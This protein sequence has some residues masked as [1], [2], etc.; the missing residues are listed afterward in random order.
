MGED[1]LVPLVYPRVCGG[2]RG[3]HSACQTR[4]GLSP[5]VRGNPSPPS[6]PPAW[7]GSIPA[8]AGE[9]CI[10]CHRPNNR[11]VY[12]RVCGGTPE[13]LHNP[14]T[15]GGLSPRVRGN[16]A[17]AEHH[18]QR[19]RSIPACAGE[20][21]LQGQRPAPPQVYPRV[22]GGTSRLPLGEM[23][24]RGLSPRVRGNPVT[25]EVIDAGTGSIP[26][27]A[28]EPARRHGTGRSCWVYPRVCGG[29]RA[30]FSRGVGPDGL[31]PRVRGNPGR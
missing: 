24:S 20:P 19:C 16:P 31:S 8:C 1:V 5:R 15:I 23:A 13:G 11:R 4:R 21:V 26:A 14:A 7:P 30:H 2:T 25:L 28:G 10:E 3:N 17:R 29:T 27:C 22:C 9:P 18:A 6:G 12:P